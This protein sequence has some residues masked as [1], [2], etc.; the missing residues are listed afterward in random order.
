ME[1]KFNISYFSF[2]F[3]R[4]GVQ[5]RAERETTNEDDCYYDDGDNGKDRQLKSVNH[6]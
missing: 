3:K 5:V 2:I 4:L 6:K 1:F